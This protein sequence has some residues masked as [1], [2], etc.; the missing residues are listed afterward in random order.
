MAD[1]NLNSEIPEDSKNKTDMEESSGETVNEPLKVKRTRRR[2]Y[3]SHEMH[4]D[5]SSLENTKKNQSDAAAARLTAED[6]VTESALDER[7]LEA[8]K[9][10]KKY[11]YLSASTGLIPIPIVDFV[12]V[13]GLEIKMIRELCQLYSVPFSK[14]R[15]KTIIAGIIGG[16]NASVVAGS[17]LKMVPFVGV[18]IAA[19]SIAAVSGAVT[20]GIGVVFMKH[21]ASGGTL[22]DL[23]PERA[24]HRFA[25]AVD[26]GEIILAQKSHN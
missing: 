9:I 7:V 23:R 19:S 18:V 12:A 3:E 8:E 1:E 2:L 24:K 20:Y 4:E 22:L 10:I 26:D 6:S 11:T 16:W 5:N 17:L 21:F 15:V 14:E 13:M 25:A